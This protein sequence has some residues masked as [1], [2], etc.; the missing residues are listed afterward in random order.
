MNDTSVAVPSAGLSTNAFLDRDYAEAVVLSCMGF[1]FVSQTEA[2]VQKA[3]NIKDFDLIRL[4]GGAKNLSSPGIKS[5]RRAV[6]A[7]IAL[8]IESH[9]VKKIIL[10]NHQACGK[11]AAEGHSWKR[12]DAEAERK[13]HHEELRRAGEY[14]KKKFPQTEVLL[15]YTVVTGDKVVIE[16]VST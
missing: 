6:M 16:P 10:L 12:S 11:Y 2:A 5:R 1:R 13:F 4:A 8:A 7:D 14:A 9:H 15:G 3:F